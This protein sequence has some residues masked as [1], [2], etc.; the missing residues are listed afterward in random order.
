MTTLLR[1]RRQWQ[2]KQERSSSEKGGGGGGGKRKDSV[3]RVFLVAAPDWAPPSPCRHRCRSNWLSRVF[4]VRRGGPAAVFV[5][6]IFP[7]FLS[8][9]RAIFPGFVCVWSTAGGLVVSFPE[10]LSLLVV[11]PSS[12]GGLLQCE[13]L[14]IDCVGGS[15]ESERAT[16]NGVRASSEAMS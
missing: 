15:F 5:V 16:K 3:E 2:W 7:D 8:L 1:L 10:T 9:A 12:W 6:K 4:C 11:P 13:P 14:A